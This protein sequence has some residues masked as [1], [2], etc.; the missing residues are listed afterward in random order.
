RGGL[1]GA[2]PAAAGGPSGAA[3]GSATPATVAAADGSVAR[4]IYA[5]ELHSSE[6]VADRRQIESFGPLLSALR[7][8]GNGAVESAV[9][10][11]VYSGT[12]IVRLRVSRG[13]RLLADIGGP[14]ILAPVTGSLRS[15][16]RTIAH[17]S[18]SVQDDAGYIK[19]VSRFVGIPV[20]LRTPKGQPPIEGQ[21]SGAPRKIPDRGPVTFHGAT[22]EAYSFTV[23]AYP[24][25][26]LRV[27]LL[28]PPRTGLSG[29]S[30]GQ[31]RATE[32]GRV[33]AHVARRFNSLTTELATYAG[34]VHALTGARVIIKAGG[35]TYLA[36]GS[37]VPRRLPSSGKVTIGGRP[38]YVAAVGLPGGARE[39]VLA[40]G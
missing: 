38:Y 23:N 26:T 1:A 12:H 11:L 15:G 28:S 34:L 13:S 21:P 24:Q 27:S 2:Q 18:F 39:Y 30:C 32:M 33:A 19:L 3:C 16:G 8:G 5:G 9:H 20:V 31:V 7:S 4:G 10:E 25:G 29:S 35:H 22:F 17:F 14:Y 6:T 36:G 37:T 40:A